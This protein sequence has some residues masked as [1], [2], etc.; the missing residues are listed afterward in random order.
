[1][2]LRVRRSLIEE[3]NR[4][5]GQLHELSLEAYIPNLSDILL[6]VTPIILEE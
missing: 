3:I 4:L 6:T 1:M 2:I 5:P